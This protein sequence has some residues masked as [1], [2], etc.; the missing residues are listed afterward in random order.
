MPFFHAQCTCEGIHPLLPRTKVQGR[1]F[2]TVLI[3]ITYHKTIFINDVDC[4]TGEEEVDPFTCTLGM[5]KNGITKK[6]AQ[7]ELCVIL[8]KWWHIVIFQLET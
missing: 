6:I 4:C 3:L 1:H 8:L 2:K 5:K 7:L